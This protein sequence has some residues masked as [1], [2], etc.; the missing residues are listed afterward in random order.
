MFTCAITFPVL[1]QSEE[2]THVFLK[3]NQYDHK[4]TESAVGDADLVHVQYTRYCMQMGIYS[5]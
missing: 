5:V 1:W 3:V 2:R 4:D